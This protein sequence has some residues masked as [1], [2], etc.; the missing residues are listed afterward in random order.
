MSQATSS[1][2]SWL[3]FICLWKWAG[4][5]PWCWITIAQLHGKLLAIVKSPTEHRDTLCGSVWSAVDLLLWCVVSGVPRSDCTVIS[6]SLGPSQQ[7]T[8]EQFE[9]MS[10]MWVCVCVCVCVGCFYLL[11]GFI[12]LSLCCHVL[13]ADSCLTCAFIHA[14]R[15]DAVVLVSLCSDILMRQMCKCNL[16][17]G[18]KKAAVGCHISSAQSHNKLLILLL[19][20]CGNLDFSEL[21]EGLFWFY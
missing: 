4:C 15:M 10:G 12:W 14:F 8:G 19:N 17:C 7:S 2:H 21:H 1:V 11:C 16:S 5:C 18:W 6:C 20:L 9:S 3:L 13:E